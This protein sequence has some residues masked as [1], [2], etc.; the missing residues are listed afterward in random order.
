MCSSLHL[1]G[2]EGESKYSKQL[3]FH[4]FLT[5]IIYISKRILPRTT[6]EQLEC[7]LSFVQ[8][9]PEIKLHKNDSMNELA[10]Q[11]NALRGPT[12]I[13]TKWKAG[14]SVHF[15]FSPFV[16]I[17]KLFCFHYRN[18]LIGGIKFVS[19]MQLI[20]GDTLTWLITEKYPFPTQL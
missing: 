18:S 13:P 3:H 7:Y 16:F 15:Y 9:H 2:I 10:K 19:G 5:I 12:R 20:L 8:A 6:K 14:F 17:R 11:L 4:N 1:S